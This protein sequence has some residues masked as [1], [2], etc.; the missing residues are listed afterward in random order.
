MEHILRLYDE[1]Y[2]F[3]GA[4]RPGEAL[5]R[6]IRQI[7]GETIEAVPS[8]ARVGI[9]ACGVHTEALL[10]EFDFSQKNVVGVFDRQ[11]I[12]KTY[13]GYSCYSA[14]QIPELG[15]E[16][17]IIS[18][19]VFRHEIRE[20]LRECNVQAIDLYGELEKRGIS[21]RRPY[22]DYEPGFPMALNY[23]YLEYLRSKGGP[24]REQA[25]IEALQA[26]VE[27]KDFVMVHRI[28]EENGGEQGEYPILVEAWHKTKSLLHAIRQ[29]VK[30]RQQKDIAVFWTDAVSFGRMM[31]YMP[32][33]KARAE[34]G[35][36]FQRAYTHTP[37]TNPTLRAMFR[38]LLPIDDFAE[39][40]VKIDGENS[41]LI[42]YLEGKGYGVK[43]ITDSGRAIGSRYVIEAKRN[44]LCHEKW[45]MGLLSF[46]ASPKPCFY[47]FHFLIESHIPTLTPDLQAFAGDIYKKSDALECQTRT[48]LAYLDQSL[49]LFNW[50]LGGKIQVFLS[51]HGDSLQGSHHWLDE[52]IH[53]YCLAVGEGISPQ[54]VSRFFQYRH[55]LQFAQW[56]VEPDKYSLDE[57]CTDW[58]VFQDVDFYDPYRVALFIRRGVPKEAIAYRGVV[59]YGHKYAINGVGEE[60]F[61]RYGQDAAEE[62]AILENGAL[63][64]ELRE[65]CK[66]TFLDISQIAKFQYSRKLYESI[67]S[68]G[69]GT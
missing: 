65:K 49:T 60:F 6:K 47:I 17:I 53:A 10:A 21:L 50:L 69:E 9:R 33:M 3:L 56:L 2:R 29:A 23:F 66:D 30:A 27:C 58:A 22:Y 37:Y 45:W 46:L 42:Q 44:I 18:S 25:L 40:Q 54:R 43:L 36:F 61:Y 67:C 55:F 4:K 39:T 26:A 41:P 7:I 57:A 16:Y 5:C 64:A 24:R 12:D 1:L 14:Q 20:E 28:Y 52:R 62:P 15:C 31:E 8:G 68:S 59:D 34:G 48:A 35:C 13:C 32:E 51:D 19:Y 11:A 38:G 63:R